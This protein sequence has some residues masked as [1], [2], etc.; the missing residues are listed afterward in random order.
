VGGGGERP[1]RSRTHRPRVQRRVAWARGQAAPKTGAVTFVQRFGVL[2][3]LKVNFHLVVPDGVF[4]E[5]GAMRP[6][7]V[8]FCG[9][10]TVIRRVRTGVRAPDA[11]GPPGGQRRVSGM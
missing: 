1:H 7:G 2:V 5:A 6:T 3:N 11:R 10:V 8:D 9:L 4:V